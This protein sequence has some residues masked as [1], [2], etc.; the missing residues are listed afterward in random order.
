ML[1]APGAIDPKSKLAK[2]LEPLSKQTGNVPSDMV[3]A[4][5]M[6]EFENPSEA[7]AVIA[8]YYKKNMILRNTY[9]NSKLFG[10]E[11]PTTYHFRRGTSIYGG[12]VKDTYGSGVD[13]DLTDAAQAT[14]LVLR[15]Q[16]DKTMIEGFQSNPQ[17]HQ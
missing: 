1:A 7:G 13:Y 3:I 12:V 14:K 15:K 4:N 2:I 8:D 5:I 17:G 10:I 9:M 16:L 6:S 11:L